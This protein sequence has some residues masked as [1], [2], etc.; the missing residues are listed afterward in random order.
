[1]HRWVRSRRAPETP[2]ERVVRKP[3]QADQ[4]PAQGQDVADACRELQITK[5]IH[6]GL[7]KK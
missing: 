6:K 1:M 7:L 4:L 5:A 2:P 3:T